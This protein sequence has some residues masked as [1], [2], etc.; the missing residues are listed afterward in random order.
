[1]RK[2]VRMNYTL[3]IEDVI[4]IIQDADDSH[5]EIIQRFKNLA[6]IIDYKLELDVIKEF[7]RKLETT[8]LVVG[9]IDDDNPNRKHPVWIFKKYGFGVMCYI[10]LKIINKNRT[11][12]VISLHEDERRDA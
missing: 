2:G 5:I 3:T 1:M 6:F 4:R 10:K 12:I 8:D 11:V 7:I 9:P